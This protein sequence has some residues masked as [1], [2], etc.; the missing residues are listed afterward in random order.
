MRH[1][2]QHAGTEV[3]E[4]LEYIG[5]CEHN[6]PTPIYS[7]SPFPYMLTEFETCSWRT[8]DMKKQRLIQSTWDEFSRKFAKRQRLPLGTELHLY[9]GSG[10]K[11]RSDWQ[12]KWKKVDSVPKAAENET[13]HSLLQTATKLLSTDIKARRL[14]IRLVSPQGV[15]IQANTQVGTVRKLR[16]HR[17]GDELEE[18]AQRELEI[19]HLRRETGKV[20]SNEINEAEYLLEDPEEVV[21]HAYVSALCERYGRE[22]IEGALEAV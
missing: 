2:L 8:D 7:H 4:R 1:N 15:R 5:D 16:R 18:E 13:V 19:K 3:P 22:R 11:K 12:V 17:T 14:K 10:R 20:A 9:D 6:K 21:P